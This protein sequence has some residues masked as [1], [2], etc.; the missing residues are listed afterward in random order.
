MLHSV[1]HV[2]ARSVHTD[3]NIIAGHENRQT[4]R[5]NIRP[6]SVSVPGFEE[7]LRNIRVLRVPVFSNVICVLYIR[8]K[9]CEEQGSGPLP[10]RYWVSNIT[11][12][13][14]IDVVL[15]PGATPFALVWVEREPELSGGRRSVRLDSH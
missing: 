3:I 14:A 11:R 5:S 12:S 1:Q 10:L 6:Y 8:F 13:P 4:G 7:N 2:S 15:V 9:L